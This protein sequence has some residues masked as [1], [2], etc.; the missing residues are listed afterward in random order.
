MTFNLHFVFLLFR[1]LFQNQH[2][3]AMKAQKL[4]DSFSPV[5]KE[6]ASATV[7]TAAGT[8]MGEVEEEE[9]CG[10]RSS[11]ARHPSRKILSASAPATVPTSTNLLGSFEE[12]V[13]NGRLEPVSTVEGFTA[14]IGASG[15]FHPKHK[16][17]PVTVF[18]YTLCDNSNISSP[19]LGMIRIRSTCCPYIIY[20]DDL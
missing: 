20:F 18:F 17:L 10:V 19:Y 3:G 5:E 7:A 4:D 12:S 13:L 9:G 2:P 6:N 15:S 16:T 14:E 1:A 8:L 11:R